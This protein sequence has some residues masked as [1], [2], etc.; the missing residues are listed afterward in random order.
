M[1][2]Y[3]GVA[4]QENVEQRERLDAERTERLRLE[5]EAKEDAEVAQRSA[6]KQSIAKQQAQALKEQVSWGSGAAVWAE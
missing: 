4:A 3:C 1:C 5:K 2:G 6:H